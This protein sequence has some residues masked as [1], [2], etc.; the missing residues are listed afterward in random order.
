VEAAAPLWIVSS[1]VSGY[2]SLFPASAL[3]ACVKFGLEGD[4]ACAAP[5]A[6]TEAALVTVT[7]RCPLCLSSLIF[8]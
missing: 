7:G 4:G 2:I 8:A 5:A 6:A 1:Q 3:E